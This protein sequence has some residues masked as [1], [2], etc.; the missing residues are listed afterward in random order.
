MMGTAWGAHAAWACLIIGAA[1]I[2][3]HLGA[4]W[5]RRVGRG[6]ATHEVVAAAM[7]QETA[8]LEIG[9]GG[10]ENKL[11]LSAV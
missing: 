9:R 11:I 2:D 5:P 10:L 7:A 4:R 1:G 6:G 3:G 8:G